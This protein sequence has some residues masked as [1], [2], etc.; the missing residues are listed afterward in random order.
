[1]RALTALARVL[2]STR[3]DSTIPSRPFGVGG[4]L[5]R[6]HAARGGFGVAR[7]VLAAVTATDPRGTSDLDH[8]DALQT[9]RAGQAG[10]DSCRSPPR[11]RGGRCRVAEP[12]AISARQAA[13]GGRKR[14][15]GDEPAEWID[16]HGGVRVAVGV[17]AEDDLALQA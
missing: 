8:L 10:A 3:I 14:L 4:R 17:D 5:A 11:R 6:E 16:E 1:M 7:V 13:A 12:S 9:Q 2:R 15:G